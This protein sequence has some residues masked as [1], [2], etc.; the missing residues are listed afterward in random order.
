MIK[1]NTVYTK[2]KQWAIDN[3]V[4][5]SHKVDFPAEFGPMKL[6]GIGALANIACNEAIIAVP[7]KLIISVKKV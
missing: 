6:A 4:L 5:I 1:E 2:F 7:N 3:G